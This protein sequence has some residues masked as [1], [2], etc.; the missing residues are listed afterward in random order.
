MKKMKKILD[1]L[2]NEDKNQLIILLFRL[3]IILDMFNLEE[4]KKE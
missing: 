4:G 1:K 3:L 2:S